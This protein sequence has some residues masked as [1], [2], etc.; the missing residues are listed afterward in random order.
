VGH[1]A[2]AY[3]FRR[4][5]TRAWALRT[6]ATCSLLVHGGSVDGCAKSK[7]R[8]LSVKAKFDGGGS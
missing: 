4:R 8:A 3:L 7:T 6:P 2:T 1:A 5:R